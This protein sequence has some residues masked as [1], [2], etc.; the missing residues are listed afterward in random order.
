MPA[1]AALM[2]SAGTAM[3]DC[4]HPVAISFA[5]GQSSAIVS[6]GESVPTVECYQVTAPS[7]RDLGMYLESAAK[8]PSLEVYAP[9]W[10]TNCDASGE[11]STSGTLMSDPGETEWIDTLTETGAYLIVIDNANGDDYRLTVEIRASGDDRS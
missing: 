10:T 4:N 3:A 7:G 6:S 5:A 11:C 8:G 1:I 9:G 2:V